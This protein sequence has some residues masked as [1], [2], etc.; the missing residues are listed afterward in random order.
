MRIPHGQSVAFES[1]QRHEIELVLTALHDASIPAADVYYS[2]TGE[3][4]A[5]G[6]T[7]FALWLVLVPTEVL[8]TALSVIAPLPVPS[9]AQPTAP[10]SLPPTRRALVVFTCLA[11]LVLLLVIIYART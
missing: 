1:G 6:Q 5:P 9:T 4:P 7:S 3:A 10:V 11:A 8:P 2:D